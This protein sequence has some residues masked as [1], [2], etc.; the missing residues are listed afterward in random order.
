MKRIPTVVILLFLFSQIVVAQEVFKTISGTVGDGRAPL[1]NVNIFVK[2][3]ERGVKTDASGKYA[4]EAKEGETLAYSYVGKK[5]IEITIEDVTTFLNV[6]L[7][8]DV[9]ELDEVVVEKR[10][11][12]SQRELFLEYNTNKNLIK[13]NFGILDKERLGYSIKII[14]GDDLSLAGIDFLNALQSWL[15]G[16]TIS[17]S[18]PTRPIAFLPRRFNSILN[19]I[20]AAYELDGVVYSEAPTFIDIASIERIAIIQSASALAKYG[21]IAAGGLII[22]NTKLNN[23]SP[24]EP[25]TDRPFDQAKLRNNFYSGD[26]A[27]YEPP[28]PAYLSALEATDAVVNAKKVYI[29]QKTI[30]GHFPHFYLDAMSFFLDRFNDRTMFESVSKEVE[31][32]FS[33]DPTILKALAYKHETIGNFDRANELYKKIFILRPHYP[34][35]YMN[36]ANSY[37][38]AGDTEKA[39]MLFARYFYLVDEGFFEAD[40]TFSEIIQKDFNGL[41]KANGLPI[42]KH[43]KV[44]KTQGDDFNGTRLVFEWNDGEAEFE[45]QFVNPNRQYYTWK[46]SL[47]DNPERIAAEKIR[48]F[49]CEE[50]LIY[51]PS[52]IWQVNV[53]Y[54]GNK[55]LTPSYLKV[56][57][58]FN[59]G[60]NA[61]RKVINEF[62]LATKNSY[63][64]LF[65][66]NNGTAL[67][68]N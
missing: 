52:G 38:D 30:Y 47:V 6:T 46:H 40:E 13:T 4:I 36:L 16:I 44:I 31:E 10:R 24:L 60:T 5:T 2:N 22:I 64:K 23:S 68:I 59:F 19:R 45:L 53:K 62:K 37:H 7:Y 26:L 35:S 61:Q 17:R 29:E 27:P 41:L 34:Q 58:Y 55:S 50:H 25:G 8:D 54:L 56:T 66:V 20:P 9:E 39:A 12:K 33:L 63:Q 51:D 28:L 49:T 15:P 18:D 14:D 21:S 48:G 11:K 65:T 42:S 3:T 32:K 1:E 57:T 67:T 43:R